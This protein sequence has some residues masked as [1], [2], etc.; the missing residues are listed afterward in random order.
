MAELSKGNDYMK[1]DRQKVIDKYLKKYD[2]SADDI[3]EYIVKD[4]RE[5]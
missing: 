5:L 1:A 4:F 3:V 2:N